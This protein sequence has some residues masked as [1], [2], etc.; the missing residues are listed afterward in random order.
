MTVSSCVTTS[1]SS[2][3]E[4]LIYSFGYV[5]QNGK[6]C[7]FPDNFSYGKLWSRIALSEP[8]PPL[9]FLQDLSKL[10]LLSGW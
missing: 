7:G 10:L 3:E 6:G 8:I 9:S 5:G 2:E 1:L 4:G